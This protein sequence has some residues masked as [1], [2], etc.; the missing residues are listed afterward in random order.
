[1]K[2]IAGFVVFFLFLSACAP[3]AVGTTP[4]QQTDGDLSLSVQKLDV[5]YTGINEAQSKDEFYAPWDMLTSR[6][7]CFPRYA[8]D[9]SY[10]QDWWWQWKVAYKLYDCG[11]NRVIA[12]E[13]RYPR[14]G[15][16]A[17]EEIKPQFWRYEMVVSD[18][19]WMINEIKFSQPPGSECPLA[20]DRSK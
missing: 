10:F 7:Q 6:T 17:A 2:N 18:E 8:C 9:I 14:T 12:E 3:A 16:A 19:R 13:L 15:S 5:F 1:M 20:L 11:S 4:V